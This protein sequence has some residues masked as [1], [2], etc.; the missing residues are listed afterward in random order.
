MLHGL[1]TPEQAGAIQQALAGQPGILDAQ[2]TVDPPEALLTV[3]HHPGIDEVQQLV[4]AVGSFHVMEMLP[5]PS[6]GHGQ[7]HDEPTTVSPPSTQHGGMHQ[8]QSAPDADDE[9]P[10]EERALQHIGRTRPGHDGYSGP[11]TPKQHQGGTG[12]DHSRMDHSQMKPGEMDHS[13]MNHGGSGGGHD[14]GAMITDFLRR[15]WVCLALSVPVVGLS[16]MFRDLTGY[17]IDFPYRNGVV[18][19]DRKSVV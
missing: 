3:E 5:A 13:K 8:P 12:M 9:S 17:T 19:V 15:F 6:S 2:V 18:L 7:H 11:D 16:M 4:S 14:H 1:T 10:A